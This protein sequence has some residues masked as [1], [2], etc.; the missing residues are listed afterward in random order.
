MFC[1]GLTD[2][3]ERGDTLFWGPLLCLHLKFDTKGALQIFE[4]NLVVICPLER[5][6]QEGGLLKV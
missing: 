4:G 1:K 6:M 5:L 3:R 2:R